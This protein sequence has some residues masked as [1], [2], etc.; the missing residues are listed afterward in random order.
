MKERP[1]DRCVDH[2]NKVSSNMLKPAFFKEV[3]DKVEEVKD[4][5]DMNFRADVL[6][7]VV[8]DVFKK[9]NTNRKDNSMDQIFCNLFEWSL[10]KVVY[11]F[12]EDVENA[13]SEMRWEDVQSHLISTFDNLP[14]NAF[15]ISFNNEYKD[16]DGD[17]FDTCVVYRDYYLKDQSQSAGLFFLFSNTNMVNEREVAFFPAGLSTNITGYENMTTIE[18]AYNANCQYFNRFKTNK[19][20]RIKLKNLRTHILP[21]I[22]YIC[23]QNAEICQPI[24]N[25]KIFKPATKPEYIKHKYREVK[26]FVCGEQT[27]CRIRNFKKQQSERRSNGKGSMKSPHV[28]RAHYHRYWKGKGS[29]RHTE[30]KWIPPI[31]IHED[32]KGY[33]KSC[34]VKV[35]K[36]Y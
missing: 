36:T 34:K 22:L 19:K 3:Y 17:V 32:L 23:S 16:K 27:G 1:V 35:K 2:W 4:D 20:N 13:L 18:D 29:N 33:I 26:Q 6:M 7:E 25:K 15:A 31:Y 30:I 10:N 11:S 9:S 14:L 24:E 5:P 21:Y 28:R 12:D 8:D